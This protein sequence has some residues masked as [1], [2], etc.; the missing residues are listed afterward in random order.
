MYVTHNAF[1]NTI[2]SKLIQHY[3]KCVRVVIYSVV[4]QWSVV[5]VESCTSIH[6][7]VMPTT[8][9][10]RRYFS[11]KAGTHAHI[12]TKF[13]SLVGKRRGFKIRTEVFQR[14][15]HLNYTLFTTTKEDMCFR[16]WADYMKEF[17]RISSF[18]SLW[19]L[20][21]KN[22]VQQKTAWRHL[23]RAPVFTNY[24]CTK[25]HLSCLWIVT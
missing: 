19:I 2:D 11:R 20:K 16:M 6:T 14:S 23:I 15:V 8:A 21:K 22:K 13:T 25:N 7:S 4:N 10:T 3:Y 24:I 1:S 5:T 12:R 18:R 17:C 9:F